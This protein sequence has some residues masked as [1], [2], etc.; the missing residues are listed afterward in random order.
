MSKPRRQRTQNTQTKAVPAS[1]R[2]RSIWLA[3]IGLIALALVSYGAW[4]LTTSPSSE[5]NPDS[6]GA[7]QNLA[8]TDTNSSSQSVESNETTRVSV[9]AP[10]SEQESFIAPLADAYRRI[11]PTADGWQTEAFHEAT[12]TQL[13]H[14]ADLFKDEIDDTRLEQLVDPDFK[15]SGFQGKN[16]KECLINL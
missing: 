7:G 11:D 14:L 3:G 10:G 6:A 4:Q 9:R 15:G 16:I 13:H 8:S 2:S 1:A 12:N 5:L